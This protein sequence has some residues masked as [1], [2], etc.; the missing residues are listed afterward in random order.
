MKVNILSKNFPL[1]SQEL[2]RKYN[3]KDGGDD[4][5]IAYTDF[6]KKRVAVFCERIK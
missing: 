2:K 4:Y 5:I 6:E 1:S 3:L